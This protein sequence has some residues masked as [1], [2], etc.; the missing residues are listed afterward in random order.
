MMTDSDQYT[1]TTTVKSYSPG[2]R[3]QVLNFTKSNTVF[4]SVLASKEVLEVTQD[5][6]VR[7]RPRVR[8]AS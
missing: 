1:L 5:D 6:I 8:Y 3:V 2:T 7:L 4:I